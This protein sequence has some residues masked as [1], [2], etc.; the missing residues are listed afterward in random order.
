MGKKSRQN[1]NA[2]AQESTVSP[3]QV[4]FHDAL[5]ACLPFPVVPS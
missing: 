4:C 1:A 5:L 2:A 3:K